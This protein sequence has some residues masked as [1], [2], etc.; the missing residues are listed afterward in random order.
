MASGEFDKSWVK[1]NIDDTVERRNPVSKD[2]FNREVQNLKERLED[3]KDFYSEN[4]KHVLKAIDDVNDNVRV[5]SH[6]EHQCKN[7]SELD[8][9][10]NRT[11][12]NTR[13]VKNM[14]K[15]IA[16]ILFTC[17]LSVTG[18]IV[19]FSNSTASIK[20]EIKENYSK[21]ENIEKDV[22]ELK[23]EVRKSNVIFKNPSL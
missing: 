15:F 2:E 17:L 7:D 19:S 4:L 21:I 13:S 6:K 10:E 3:H 12:E 14:Y 8:S 20:V 5:L 1:K 11:N 9:I 18:A 16:G 22:D 23:A